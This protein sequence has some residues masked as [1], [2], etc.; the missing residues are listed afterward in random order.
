[1]VEASKGLLEARSTV[2]PSLAPTFEGRG[3]CMLPSES[4][5]VNNPSELR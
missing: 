3:L 2:A 5:A 1:M 4:R